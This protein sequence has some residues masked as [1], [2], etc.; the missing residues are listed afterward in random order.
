MKILDKYPKYQTRFAFK[1]IRDKIIRIEKEI[2]ITKK[3]HNEAISRVIKEISYFP[4][5]IREAED[6]VKKFEDIMEEANEKLK[7]SRFNKGIFYR[8][9]EEKKKAETKIHTLYYEMDKYK[10]TIKQLKEEVV[11]A[12]KQDLE[13]MDY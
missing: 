9:S 3:K 12:K 2:K 1:R 5:N 13:E 4:R 10:N 8:F 7:K 6:L 11:K